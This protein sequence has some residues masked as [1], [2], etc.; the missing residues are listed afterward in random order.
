LCEGWWVDEG[1]G[2]VGGC[3]VRMDLARLT[4][5]IGMQ[6]WSAKEL[7]TDGG[8]MAHACTLARLVMDQAHWR[9]WC[10]EMVSLSVG[11]HLI[12]R[13]FSCF[14]EDLTYLW[15]KSAVSTPISGPPEGIPMSNPTQKRKEIVTIADSSL[16]PS[17]PG[18]SVLWQL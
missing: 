5:W 11:I 7:E 17:L 1:W 18:H 16:Q 10:K 12:Q 6:R 14:R 15:S 9:V 4:F 8:H 13:K 2:C 3:L